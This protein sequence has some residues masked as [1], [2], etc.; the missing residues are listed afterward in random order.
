MWT[1]HAFRLMSWKEGIFKMAGRIITHDEQFVSNFQKVSLFSTAVK[2]YRYGMLNLESVGMDAFIDKCVH[3]GKEKTNKQTNKNSTTQFLM[4]SS[5]YT[6]L[7]P[8]IDIAIVLD[9]LW[10]HQRPV[11]F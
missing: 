6:T 3:F 7:Q 1:E 5:T 10:C 2:C 11:S 8:N 4:C 9:F